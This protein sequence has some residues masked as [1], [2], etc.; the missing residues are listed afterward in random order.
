MQGQEEVYEK[1]R[2]GVPFA[3]ASYVFYRN[4]ERAGNIR[5][6]RSDAERSAGRLRPFGR[7]T[8]YGGKRCGGY[9]KKIRFKRVLF[10]FGNRKARNAYYHR[11]II[12]RR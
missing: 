2:G 3:H 7:N 12:N 5:K 1:M 11:K 8:R 10:L 9:R 6:S 4:N